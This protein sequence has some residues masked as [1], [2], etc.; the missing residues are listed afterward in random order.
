VPGPMADGLSGLREVNIYSPTMAV[1]PVA[2]REVTHS[3]RIRLG[4][5][6]IRYLT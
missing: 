3:T 2:Y 1:T 6:G 5:R 4:E